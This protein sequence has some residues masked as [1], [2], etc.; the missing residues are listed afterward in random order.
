MSL[1]HIK[2]FIYNSLISL[3]IRYKFIII[4][5]L[6]LFCLLKYFSANHDHQDTNKNVLR[7]VQYEIVKYKNISQ[8]LSL[9][10]EIAAK[11][12]ASLSFRVDGKLIERLVSLGDKVAANQIIAK[13][14]PQDIKDS[15]TTAKSNLAAAEAVFKQATSE[16]ARQKALYD[17]QY[18]T[19]AQYDKVVQQLQSAKSQVDAA[20][21][22]LNQ[23]QSRLSY[24]DLRSDVAGI[25]TKTFADAGEVVKSGQAIVKIATDEGLD[26]VFNVP[27]KL[28]QKKFKDLSI[29]VSLS[30]NTNIKALGT[31]R[32]VSPQA[33][34]ITR[35][36]T[37]K[38]SL[39]NPPKEM[40]LGSTIIGSVASDG[41]LA[42]ELPASSLNKSN[43]HPAVWVVD[44]NNHTLSLRN[45]T[46]DDYTQE[47]VIVTDGLKDGEIVVTA[48][49]QSLYPTQKVKLLEAK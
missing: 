17:K 39:T 20:N 1:D 21:A 43:G 48:G 12:E 14:D 7:P 31:I 22:S 47:S 24:T 11:N 37:V 30:Y 25:V 19:K 5:I 32:Q 8:P 4:A 40:K 15:L 46:I 26:A 23:A 2:E 38:V 42:V 9:T 10:G 3:I 44:P 13:L 49:I 34:P 16:E 36:F 41:G 6:L 28:F 45:I 27:E 29:E 18:T 33:D 35:T